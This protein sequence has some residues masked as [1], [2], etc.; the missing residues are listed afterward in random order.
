[1]KV[2]LYEDA[3]IARHKMMRESRS[4][5]CIVESQV[6]Y[7]CQAAGK[8][9]TYLLKQN[10][11]KSKNQKN[12]RIDMNRFFPREKNGKI[13]KAIKP[14]KIYGKTIDLDEKMIKGNI[15]NANNNLTF[16]PSTA[17]KSQQKSVKGLKLYSSVNDK[18]NLKIK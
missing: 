11:I 9:K 16:R 18:Q 7:D 2:V 10:K 5:K 15:M 8:T 12:S 17:N 3:N 4:Q 13:P 6:E 14:T 1:M